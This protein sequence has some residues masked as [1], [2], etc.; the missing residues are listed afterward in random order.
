MNNLQARIEKTRD[1]VAELAKQR[2]AAFSLDGV[3]A[4]WTCQHCWNFH[5]AWQKWREALG[6]LEMLEAQQRRERGAAA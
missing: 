4:E 1:E 5:T 2:K 3:A 6:R